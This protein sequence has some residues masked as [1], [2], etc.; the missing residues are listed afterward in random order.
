MI[1]R[2]AVVEYV[3]IARR[4]QEDAV[5]LVVRNC[6]VEYVVIARTPQVDAIIIAHYVVIHDLAVIC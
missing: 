5:I 3:V 4:I 2:S 1:V 6:V